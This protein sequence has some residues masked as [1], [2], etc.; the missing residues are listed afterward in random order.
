MGKRMAN[1]PIFYTIAQIVFNPVLTMGDYVPKFHARLRKDFP[2]FKQEE[3]HQFQLNIA[4]KSGKEALSSHSALRWSFTHIKQTSGYLLRPESI[5]FHT[6]AYETWE[7]FVA[8]LLHGV[9]L[10]NELV[11]LSYIDR[12]GIRTLDAVVSETEKP[13][14]FFL[15]QEVLGFQN[16]LSGEMKYNMSENVTI[17]PS[18]QLVS[19]VVLLS[20]EQIGVP[21][22]LFPIALRLPT[23][24]QKSVGTHAVIDL[25]HAQQDRFEFDIEEVRDRIRTGK[26][27]IT[28]V[29][30]SVVTED[31][32]RHWS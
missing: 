4:E 12:V 24:L 29:F 10:I 3:V 2:E 7:E 16:F 28:E 1:P 13:L 30:K 32:L 6:T 5:S 26:A 21:V 11:G 25:D 27:R 31:A 15:R 14:A 19:R 22:D 18:G 8:A 17:G 23:R 20:S 9:S